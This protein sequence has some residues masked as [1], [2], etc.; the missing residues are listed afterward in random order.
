M[1]NPESAN[2]TWIRSLVAELKLAREQ[3]PAADLSQSRTQ[4]EMS[5]V[6]E[7]IRNAVTEI[8]DELGYQ[9]LYFLD[10]LPPHR[11]IFRVSFDKAGTRYSL[12]L[13]VRQTGPVAVFHCMEKTPGWLG[14]H[15]FGRAHF[16]TSRVVCS[17]EFNSSAIARETIQ[18]WVAYVL[19]GFNRKYNPTARSASDMK[20]FM[21]LP[22]AS[23]I[24]FG[25]SKTT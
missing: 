13:V 7:Q 25:I 12:E 19:S 18:M 15:I 14:R 16:S 24:Q 1:G 9:A 21:T 6:C 4:L 2:K 8:N 23:E 11:S 5:D 17:Q 22:S 10:F 20:S 3:G